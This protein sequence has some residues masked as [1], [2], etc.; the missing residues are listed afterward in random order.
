[1]M[2]LPKKL[3]KTLC[4]KSRKTHQCFKVSF[5]TVWRAKYFTRINKKTP[6]QIKEGIELFIVETERL[7]ICLSLQIEGI[8]KV[9]ILSPF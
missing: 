9:H 7:K 5:I 3:V 2:Q 6:H 1:M 8:V 4:L